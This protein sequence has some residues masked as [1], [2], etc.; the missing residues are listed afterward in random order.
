MRDIVA[1]F[2]P[3]VLVCV[4]LGIWWPG[5]SVAIILALV[6]IWFALHILSELRLHGLRGDIAALPPDAR[7][8][9]EAELAALDPKSTR[10]ALDV[11][12]P[13]YRLKLLRAL[14]S[15]ARELLL[16]ALALGL[17]FVPPLLLTLYEEGQVTQRSQFTWRHLALFLLSTAILVLL[18]RRRSQSDDPTDDEIS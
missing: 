7:H 2:L 13:P 4:G 3:F 5:W 1:S 11:E 15:G 8:D 17:V 9:L 16:V 14:G 10:N 6:G 12:P 18:V